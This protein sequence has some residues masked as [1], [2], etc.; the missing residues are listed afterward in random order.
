MPLSRFS[1]TFQIPHTKG[2]FPH[3]FNTEDHYNYVGSLHALEY[4]DPDGLKEPARTE[5]I[6]WH[7][8]HADDVFDFAQRIDSY[9]KADVQ[10]LKSGC[11]L[12]RNA[13]IADTVSNRYR[14]ARLQVHV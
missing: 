3:L 11:M 2:T 6:K 7:N 13:F 9:C 8:D 10:L 1:D 14:I 5:L 4:Y 12:F